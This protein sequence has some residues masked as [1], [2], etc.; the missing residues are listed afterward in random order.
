MCRL[1]G[2]QASVSTQA[3]APIEVHDLFTPKA[4]LL[5]EAKAEEQELAFADSV[6]GLTG[7][8]IVKGV[9]TKMTEDLHFHFFSKECYFY[10]VT[11]WETVVSDKANPD[12]D[13]DDDDEEEEEADEEL[14][15]LGFFWQGR[16]AGNVPWISFNF[17]GQRVELEERIKTRIKVGSRGGWKEGLAWTWWR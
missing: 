11:Y 5:D 10:L 1:F 6:D 8:R 15:A 14:H 4:S 17:G 16:D 3:S 13:D 12:D 9:L 2:G 7:Y